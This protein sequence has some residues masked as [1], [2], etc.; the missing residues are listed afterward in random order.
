MDADRRAIEQFPEMY[1]TK[2]SFFHSSKF[3]VH[4]LFYTGF[5]IFVCLL[6]FYVCSI[7]LNDESSV[8]INRRD[9]NYQNWTFVI[10]RCIYSRTEQ[11]KREELELQVNNYHK[12]WR[13]RNCQSLLTTLGTNGYT[14]Q[15]VFTYNVA[16]FYFLLI[17]KL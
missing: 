14:V 17:W 9:Y 15:A 7:C 16:Y 4:I 8:K 12:K 5:G 6:S 10:K 1:M 13:D 3:L 2:R 11:S